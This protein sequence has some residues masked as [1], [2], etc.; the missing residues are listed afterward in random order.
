MVKICYLTGM[1]AFDTP[2]EIGDV[3][4]QYSSS[5]LIP[6]DYDLDQGALFDPTT[7]D[8]LTVYNKM[9]SYAAGMDLND[10][11]AFNISTGLNY[12]ASSELAKNSSEIPGKATFKLRSTVT[13]KE[14]KDWL[15]KIN[16]EPA[17]L[18]TTDY[19]DI[20]SLDVKDFLA[21]KRKPFS[22]RRSA[23]AFDYD[24]EMKLSRG[25]FAQTVG[26]TNILASVRASKY[27]DSDILYAELANS[28]GIDDIPE[29]M[30]KIRTFA[31]DKY[32]RWAAYCG[33]RMYSINSMLSV[34][35]CY[36]FDASPM[37][38]GAFGSDFLIP[39]PIID[40]G[41]RSMLGALFD[42]IP[43]LQADPLSGLMNSHVG[44][45]ITQNTLPRRSFT[46]GRVK[47][48]E[49]AMIPK[50][51]TS[52]G[53]M[54]LERAQLQAL[55]NREILEEAELKYIDSVRNTIEGPDAM[56]KATVDVPDGPEFKVT[57]R[58][59]SSGLKNLRRQAGRSI[60][61]L[62]H[63]TAALID[64]THEAIKMTA[65]DMRSLL[66][67]ALLLSLSSGDGRRHIYPIQKAVKAGIRREL[68]SYD[69]PDIKALYAKNI[70]YTFDG[71]FFTLMRYKGFRAKDAEFELRNYLNKEFSCVPHSLKDNNP[72]SLL[73]ACFNH[74]NGVYLM[75]DFRYAAFNLMSAYCNGF[76]YLAELKK[77][78]P[79]DE[80]AFKLM[81]DK[82]AFFRDY[83]TG[84]A[85]TLGD[86]P[87]KDLSLAQK[88]DL[89]LSQVLVKIYK[90]LMVYST[91]AQIT[92]ELS[93]P[94]VAKILSTIILRRYK[95]I[96]EI[97]NKYGSY[98]VQHKVINPLTGRTTYKK[99]VIKT[100]PWGNQERDFLESLPLD[101]LE[102]YAESLSKN[103]W[104]VD[105]KTI[106]LKIRETLSSTYN[107]LY[108]L[109]ITDPSDI[110]VQNST[111][112]DEEDLIPDPT[113][114]PQTVS[115][116][117]PSVKGE[118]FAVSQENVSSI[119]TAPLLASTLQLLDMADSFGESFNFA[120]PLTHYVDSRL[121]IDVV[122]TIPLT[123]RCAPEDFT[124]AKHEVEKVL[125]MEIAQDTIMAD[126][127]NASSL[128]EESI[129]LLFEAHLRS[130]VDEELKDDM[131]FESSSIVQR[132]KK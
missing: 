88:E 77:G 69:S 105:W 128:P 72:I 16:S 31:G 14:A 41:M 3:H 81:K 2:F 70:P 64:P 89:I 13:E 28:W 118:V 21:G 20:I 48:R 110:M 73:A 7:E 27:H 103:G 33:Q 129:I 32:T 104:V 123:K 75:R 34:A 19:L 65:P 51:N 50:N 54:F 130:I 38:Q 93:K 36:T 9:R 99:E 80:I 82:I 17:M 85:Q 84:K 101:E 126:I 109:L 15:L 56:Y 132:S 35:S 66:K 60:V 94:D 43:E 8:V 131:M 55:K 92:M 63:R 95:S 111:V 42:S 39:W 53:A 127:L 26:A 23:K 102:K 119:S 30:R 29:D 91:G 37:A 98:T 59:V 1:I 114:M 117:R 121:F 62:A 24:K 122:R 78:V 45:H 49:Q 107:D 79:F 96:R 124:R 108:K 83:Y 58:V 106:A 71:H 12:A 25:A 44:F 113:I 87:L 40:V 11:A 10:P 67:I 90:N 74:R 47:E 52:V 100:H 76:S 125:K 112:E 18:G 68:T 86:M 120:E 61:N 22:G 46:L 6:A 57:K 97:L 4:Q 5:Y 116:I 115:D